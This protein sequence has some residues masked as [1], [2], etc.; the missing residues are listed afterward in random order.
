[1]ISKINSISLKKVK[2]TNKQLVILSF[3][4]GAFIAF[5][6][7]LSV[8]IAGDM[9]GISNSNPGLTRFVFASL[10]PLGLILV[11]L[12]EVELFTGNNSYMIVGVLN[13]EFKLKKLAR[14]FTWVF[15]FN[16]LG[17]VFVAFFFGY[18]ADIM[19]TNQKDFIVNIAETKINLSFDVAFIR[20]VACNWLVCLALWMAAKTQS[21]SAKVLVLW[22]PIMAFVAMGF[23]HSIA[24][25]F[26]IPL[27]MLNGADISLYDFVIGNIIPVTLGNNVGGGIFVAIL[28][29]YGNKSG[30]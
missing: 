11:A 20:A 22:F 3:L 15:V 7:L 12:M 25:M 21:F 14:N 8:I 24:N 19:N 23:E 4:G 26:F 9:P 18:Y 5:G 28:H 10:F 1:M 30:K 13:K 16:F 27:A 2:Y 6:G 29:Y 17:A